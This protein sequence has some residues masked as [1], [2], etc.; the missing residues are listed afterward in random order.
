MKDEL[1][2]SK[3]GHRHIDKWLG[4]EVVK[5]VDEMH[6][7]AYAIEDASRPPLKCEDRPRACRV[8][9]VCMPA[10]AAVQL[11]ISSIGR[12]QYLRMAGWY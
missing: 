11:Q 7:E 4:T 8:V 3:G 9:A 2:D 12:I 6:H 1:A 5:M 10:S